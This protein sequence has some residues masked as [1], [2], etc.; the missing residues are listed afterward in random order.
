MHMG[1]LAAENI[2]Q[3]MLHERERIKPEF[4][5]WPEVPPMIALAIGRKAATYAPAGGVQCG[6]EQM[7]L[8]FGDDLGFTGKS[9]SPQSGKHFQLTHFTGCWNHMK[10]SEPA[11]STGVS[12][13]SVLPQTAPYKETIQRS[14]VTA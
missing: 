14:A 5:I 1:F 6:E 7:K 12:S 10:L 3:Q 2:H 13:Y 8:F 11:D 4:S 9:R